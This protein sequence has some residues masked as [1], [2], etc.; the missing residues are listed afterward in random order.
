MIDLIKKKHWFRV[1]KYIASLLTQFFINILVI[2]KKTPSNN[3]LTK[4]FPILYSNFKKLAC[5][6]TFCGEDTC[7]VLLYYFFSILSVLAY[8]CTV[9]VPYS[10][11]EVASL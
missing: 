7:N 9:F 2:V 1:R 11:H 6:A 4:L 3:I 5:D 10:W 8:I